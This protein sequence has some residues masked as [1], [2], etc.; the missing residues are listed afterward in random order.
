MPIYDFF[1]KKCG[2]E[3]LDVLLTIAEMENCSKNP[4]L[5]CDNCKKQMVVKIGVPQIAKIASM[6]KGEKR[7]AMSKRSKDHFQRE[8]KENAQ[9]MHKDMIKAS[10]QT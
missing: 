10:T 6:S 3:K 9:Q 4:E 7:A 8:I 2:A 1:C 5:K